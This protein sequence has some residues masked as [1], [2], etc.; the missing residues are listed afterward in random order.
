MNYLIIFIIATFVGVALCGKESS[1]EPFASDFQAFN[2]AMMS[3]LSD[4]KEYSKSKY[5]KG[6]NNIMGRFYSKFLTFF[7][8]FTPNFVL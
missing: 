6:G 3:L 5:S 4:I 7:T 2:I 8:D 1:C